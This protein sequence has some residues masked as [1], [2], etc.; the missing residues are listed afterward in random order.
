MKKLKMLLVVLMVAP[1]MLMLAACGKPTQS[2]PITIPEGTYELVSFKV[3]G[4]DMNASSFTGVEENW[5]CIVGASTLEFY[6]YETL[7]VSYEYQADEVGNIVFLSAPI[8][9]I[10]N[11][12][13]EI[14][15]DPI[16][17]YADGKITWSKEWVHEEIDY[18]LILVF[19]L[20]D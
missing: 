17:T 10:P 3:N 6:L 8:E 12:I 11:T 5:K 15:A 4:E 9:V 18:E 13:T 2:D 20:V 16:V 7:S 1:V 14:F 19:E